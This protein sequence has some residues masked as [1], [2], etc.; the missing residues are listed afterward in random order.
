MFSQTRRSRLTPSNSCRWKSSV[1]FTLLELL[2]IVVI[3]GVLAALAIP[4]YSS[5]VDKAKRTV[6]LAVSDT[7]RKDL[8]NFSIDNQ[9]YP[10]GII[11]ATGKENPG[12][13]TV[14][15]GTFIEQVNSDIIVTDADYI[16]NPVTLSYVLTVKAKDKAQT[17]ITLTPSETSF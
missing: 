6:A 17:I 2:I 5:Y 1:G 7:I 12:N 11:F 8:E 10:Q 4:T 3:I 14:F 9:R 16:Y 13:L 15:S